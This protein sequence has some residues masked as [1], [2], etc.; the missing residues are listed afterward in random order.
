MA[1]L[2]DPKSVTMVVDYFRSNR[3][4][5]GHSGL[6]ELRGTISIL[7]IYISRGNNRKLPSLFI[8]NDEGFSFPSQVG[9]DQVSF[10]IANDKSELA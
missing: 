6:S 10:I 7:F 1:A 9:N 4:I 2:S 8:H 3:G 5:P